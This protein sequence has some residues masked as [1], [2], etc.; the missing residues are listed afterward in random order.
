MS[1]LMHVC[2]VCRQAYGCIIGDKVRECERDCNFSCNDAELCD[3][4][5]YICPDCANGEEDYHE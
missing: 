5:Y 2:I 1:K 3:L 4:Q